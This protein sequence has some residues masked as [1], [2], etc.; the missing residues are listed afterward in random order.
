M[1]DSNILQ[2]K[3]PLGTSKNFF[4]IIGNFDMCLQKTLASCDLFSHPCH[5]IRP[6]AAVDHIRTNKHLV[7]HIQYQ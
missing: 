4:E 6:C 7:F 1:E 3:I 2:F 5:C